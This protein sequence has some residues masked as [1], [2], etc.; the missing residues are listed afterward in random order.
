MVFPHE[1]Y[2]HEPDLMEKRNNGSM[3][4]QGL[5]GNNGKETRYELVRDKPI[6]HSSTGYLKRWSIDTQCLTR[7]LRLLLFN[8]QAT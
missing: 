7:C 8:L 1:I 2:E 6:N 3:I 4:S 5:P